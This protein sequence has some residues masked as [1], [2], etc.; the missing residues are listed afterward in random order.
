[1]KTIHAED[2]KTPFKIAI[3]ISRFNEEITNKLYEGAIERLKELD[4]AEENITVVWVPGAVEIPITAQRLAK[5]N[6]YAAIIC[7]GAVIQGETKHFDYVCDHVTV[8]TQ[9]LSLAFEM[10]IVFGILTTDNA[11][12]AR[13]R[14][15]GKKGHKGREAADTAYEMISVLQ[16]IEV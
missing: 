3:V 8:G 10:P 4:V 1:M 6:Q 5:S 11:Q 12:Q 15:G 7:L 2:I 14:V 16:Q 13:D 9:Q